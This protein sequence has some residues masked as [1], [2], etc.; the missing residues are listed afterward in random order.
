MNSLGNI[1]DLIKSGHKP[2]HEELL[3]AVLAIDSLLFFESRAIK[4][5]AKA[6]RLNKKPVLLRCPEYQE[7][8]SFERRQRAM[9]KSPKEYLGCNNDPSN[10]EYIKRVEQSN[11][12]Y[13]KVRRLQ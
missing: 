13:A 6:K 3:Y 5:L 10:P 8:E 1:I 12:I 2:D 9:N 11:E 4:D 7:K